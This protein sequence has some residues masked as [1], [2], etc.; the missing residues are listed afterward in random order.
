VSGSALYEGLVTHVRHTPVRHR[1]RYAMFQLLLDLDEAPG[2]GRRLRLFST[3]RFNL[4]SHHDA[5]HGE[6]RPGALRAW[7]EETLHEAGMAIDGGQILLLAM[8]RVLGHVFNPLSIY[9]CHHAD[10]A[11]VALIYEV[12]NTFGQRHFYIIGTASA[13]ERTIRQTCAKAFHVSPFLPMDMVYDFE[14]TRPAEILRTRVVGRSPCGERMIDASFAGSRHPLTDVRLAW[15]LA[16]F[17]LMTLKV[18]AAIHFEALKLWL[19]GTRLG[20]AAA[21]DAVRES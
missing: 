3:N 5:D 17:P 15:L 20:P 14:I 18:V 2:L 9:Y 6:G 13:E 7:V 12:N 1:L 11:L 19:K 21:Q 16:T 10:G 8:P 4:F